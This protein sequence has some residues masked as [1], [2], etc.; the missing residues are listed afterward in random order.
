MRKWLTRAVLPV[1]MLLLWLLLNQSVSW[2]QVLVGAALGIW[3]GW[4]SMRLRPLKARPRRIWLLPGLVWR[5]FVDVVRSN[6]AVAQFVWRPRLPMSPGFLEVPLELRDPHGLAMMACIITYT[7]GTV[8]VDISTNHI[9]TL[10]VLDLQNEEEW[11]SLI[12]RRYERT[13]IEVFD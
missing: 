12:K 8:L 9:M 11:I 6:W 10:H 1:C 7:P 3:L 13:L 4:A 5:V 2:G